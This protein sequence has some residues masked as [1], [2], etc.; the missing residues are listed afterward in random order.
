[1]KQRRFDA[2]TKSLAAAAASRRQLLPALAVGVVLDRLGFPPGPAIAG[3]GKVGDRCER[4]GECCAGARCRNGRCRCKPGRGDCDRAGRCRTDLRTDPANCGRCGAACPAEA[5]CTDGVCVCADARPACGAVGE[6]TCCAEEEACLNSA[7]VTQGICPTGA[8][9]CD[10]IESCGVAPPG[11]NCLC[12]TTP[13]GTT[14]CLTNTA[15]CLDP[16]LCAASED[17]APGLVCAE[18]AV[19][20]EG[21]SDV[22]RACL[23]PCPVPNA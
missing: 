23:E 22:V 12:A 17:C 8:T 2:W 16:L 19:C 1:M 11:G 18:V 4:G 9:A 7:C 10:S 14:A 3:C 6:L 5:T 21:L 20:C 15:F 13:E